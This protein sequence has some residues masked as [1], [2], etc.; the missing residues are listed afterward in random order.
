MVFKVMVS[1][2]KT[3]NFKIFIM[4]HFNPCFE[5]VSHNWGQTRGFLMFSYPPSTRVPYFWTNTLIT[6]WLML[7]LSVT[8]NGLN[9]IFSDHGNR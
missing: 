8:D 7:D 9:F 4:L 5:F 1:F 3:S 2:V 6:L